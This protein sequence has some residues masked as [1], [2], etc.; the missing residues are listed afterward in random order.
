MISRRE[1]VTAGVLGALATTGT[2]EAAV[3]QEV[4]VLKAGFKALEDK[5]EDLQNSI[6]QGLRG[7]LLSVDHRGSLVEGSRRV[8][9]PGCSLGGGR[10]FARSLPARARST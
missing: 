3:A 7:F 9:E 10:Q 2:A 6:D 5:L 8:G 4:E 1:V